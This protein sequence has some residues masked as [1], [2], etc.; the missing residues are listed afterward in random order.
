[1]SPTS[2]FLDQ[3]SAFDLPRYQGLSTTDLLVF[4]ASV[5]AQ[6]E[7]R[8]TYEVLVVAAYRYF[9][10]S[11]SLVGFP[12]YPDASRVNRT[13]LQCQPKYRNLMRGSASSQ[14]VL[15]ELGIHR[16]SE[17]AQHLSGQMPKQKRARRSRP[18][19]ILDRIEQELRTSAAFSSWRAGEQIADYDFYHLLH[20]VPGSSKA[21]IRENYDA[22]AGVARASL[23]QDIAPFLGAVEAQFPKELNR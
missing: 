18:R 8:L 20:L 4:A 16:A 3:I 15:T 11:F 19:A 23:D 5:L 9:P 6:H 17:V 1:M 10:D 22:I 12:Q 2:K 14:Y 13:L 7:H 21:S